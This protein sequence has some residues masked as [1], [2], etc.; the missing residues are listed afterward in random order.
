MKYKI[1]LVYETSII[2][3]IEAQD[4]DEAISLAWNEAHNMEGDDWLHN[5]TW[6]D[7]IVSEVAA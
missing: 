2:V 3:E 5:G 4:N 1:E 7:V 6:T